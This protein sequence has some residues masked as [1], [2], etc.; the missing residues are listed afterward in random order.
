MRGTKWQFFVSTHPGQPPIAM[1]TDPAQDFQEYNMDV[2][3]KKPKPVYLRREKENPPSLNPPKHPHGNAPPAPVHPATGQARS[4]TYG[5][6]NSSVNRQSR[7]QSTPPAPIPGE[8][9][10]EYTC[11]VDLAVKL[12]TWSDMWCFP[13]CRGT[14]RRSLSPENG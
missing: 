11:D 10:F 3:A 13:S 2:N 14:I 7:V 8:I 12:V 1:A 4:L 5:N 9:L 6:D